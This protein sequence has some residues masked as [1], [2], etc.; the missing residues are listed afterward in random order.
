MPWPALSLE[1][2]LLTAWV[3]ALW[4]IGLLVAP[5]LFAMLPDRVVAGT[6]VGRL[7]GYVDMIGLVCGSVILFSGWRR[8]GSRWF[9]NW[10]AWCLIMM[11][12]FAAVNRILLAPAMQ[13]LK[14]AA[15]GV[16]LQGTRLAEDFDTLHMI[17]GTFF[18]AASLLGLLLVAVGS[19]AA[20][21]NP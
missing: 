21:T 4:A 8:S 3:G 15:G 18:A 16:P 7:F 13:S 1:R 6:V 5:T 19:S 12:M 10:R 11:L 2:V 20:R 17:S 14:A 9:R